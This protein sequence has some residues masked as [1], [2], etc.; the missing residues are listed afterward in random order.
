MK[1]IHFILTG[2]FIPF[3]VQAQLTIAGFVEI[4]HTFA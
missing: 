4:V 2:F 1:G 3:L